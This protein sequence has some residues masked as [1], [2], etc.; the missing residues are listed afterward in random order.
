MAWMAST[1]SVDWIIWT[2]WVEWTN[3]WTK[4]S[5]ASTIWIWTTTTSW[6]TKVTRSYRTS[7]CWTRWASKLNCRTSKT[8]A[9]I[10]WVSSRISC[11]SKLSSCKAQTSRRP[12]SSFRRLSTPQTKIKRPPQF[13]CLSF[14][15]GCSKIKQFLRHQTRIC[16]S[17]LVSILVMRSYRTCSS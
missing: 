14:L 5:M 4:L 2:D 10:L 15:Q 7:L 3:R 6:T 16:P 13:R 11:N 12:T 1:T 17:A 8:S 9:I